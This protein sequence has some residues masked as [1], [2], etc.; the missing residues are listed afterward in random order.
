VHE[1][2]T[3]TGGATG[4]GAGTGNDAAEVFPFGPFG[5]ALL[6]N[7]PVG[8]AIWDTDLR[9]RWLNTTQGH[10]HGPFRH[11]RVG[12]TMREALHGFDPEVVEGA[13]R[14]VLRDGRP[15]V[16]HEFR[17]VTDDGGE[18]VTSSTLFRLDEADGTPLGV[19]SFAVDITRSRSRERLSLLSEVGVRIGT[20][21]DVIT[22]AQE[23][24]DV[25]VPLLADF[26][27]VDLAES[28]RLGGE[29]LEHL[30]PH[31]TVIPAFRRAAV[32][33]VNEGAPESAFEVGEVIYVPKGS[34]LLEVVQTREPHY[35]PIMDASANTWFIRD[36]VRAQRVSHFAM[37][38]MIV[39]PLEARR[40]VLGVAV[41]IRSTDRP[42]FTQ[43]DLELAQE[44]TVRAALHLDNARRY[45]RERRA[46]L[47]LQR[48]LLPRSL[49]GSDAVELAAE[50]VPADGDEAMGGDWFDCVH[51]SGGRV[52]LVVG[53]VVGHGMEAAATMGRM[54][55][56]AYALALL[57]LPPA[58]LLTRFDR[59][60]LNM[61]DENR[62]V[63]GFARP[64]VAGSCVYAEY[65]PAT[66]NCTVSV[67]GNLPP[68]LVSPDGH[69]RQLD[70]PVGTPIGVGE[71]GYE[72]VTVTV[73]DGSILALFTDG[74]VNG[75]MNV[76]EGIVRLEEGLARTSDDL[77][78]YCREA[79]RS[80]VLGNHRDDAT[81]LVARV[82][83]TTG[84]PDPT[85][86]GR[87]VPVPFGG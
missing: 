10:E 16:D 27:T 75:L 68:F 64:L 76:Q 39:L 28:V 9:C 23:L 87:V 45:T 30:R 15:V 12:R 50:Y 40:T 83:R 81:L 78:E 18:E 61:S 47:A 57:D 5:Q 60:A 51:L 1:G 48:N 63:D 22:T 13:M 70:L 69:S 43:D 79:A 80:A 36:P 11:R 59:A 82:R 38:S 56:A 53:D 6:H 41:F 8:L 14:Q 4:T 2:G 17:R 19:G 84:A 46:A 62:G 7:S 67:A 74:I 71:G 35:Q 33:S 3:G 25:A 29:P 52:G 72:E 44:L 54:R 65:D 21:L 34:P 86:P 26:A 32:A 73:D 77:A 24:A 58:E 37:H 31:S 55:T 49:R 85:N 20:T 42:A 66:G